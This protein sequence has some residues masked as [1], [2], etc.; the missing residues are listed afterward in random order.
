MN[1]VKFQDVIIEGDNFFNEKLKGKY[2]YAINWLYIA[3]LDLQEKEYIQI[4]KG[5][6]EVD[7]ENH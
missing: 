1:L 5:Q 2:A 7:L 6:V 3:P 4:S